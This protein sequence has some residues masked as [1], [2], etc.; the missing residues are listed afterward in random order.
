MLIPAQKPITAARPATASV[1][2]KVAL[3]VPIGVPFREM[4]KIKCEE[5]LRAALDE[6]Q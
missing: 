1:E 6:R 2:A 5:E 4:T 3:R